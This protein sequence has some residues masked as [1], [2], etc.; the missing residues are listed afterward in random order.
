MKLFSMFNAF[1]Y[2][3]TL[4]LWK[5]VV[6]VCVVVNRS[7]PNIS[8][9][10]NVRFM[11]FSYNNGH[12]VIML[13]WIYVRY[14]N[15]CLVHIGNI[16]INNVGANCCRIIS[17]FNNVFISMNVLFCAGSL[18][19]L[20]L[21]QPFNKRCMFRPEFYLKLT[22][23]LKWLIINPSEHSLGITTKTQSNVSHTL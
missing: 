7:D 8:D 19:Y 3:C 17:M 6:M 2:I 1:V 20:M 23:L 15:S 16:T 11:C 22:I 14:L 18:A 13:F 9:W 10:Q 4:V 21:L 12:D 5:Q